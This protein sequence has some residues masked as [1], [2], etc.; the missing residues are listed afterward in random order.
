MSG[1][2]DKQLNIPI[3]ETTEAQFKHLLVKSAIGLFIKLKYA[4]TLRYQKI[5]SEFDLDGKITDIFHEN[6]KTKEIICYE[7]QDKVTSKW[8]EETTNFY[9]HFNQSG[10]TT[11]WVLVDL[12]NISDNIAEMLEQLK[13][14]IR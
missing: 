3:R 6:W 8:L 13:E 9:N 10:F 1:F 14:V 4:K 11:D 2:W 7:V 5:F 12:N